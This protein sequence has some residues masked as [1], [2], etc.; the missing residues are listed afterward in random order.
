MS[1][2]GSDKLFGHQLSVS[3]LIEGKVEIV[4]Q[5]FRRQWHKHKPGADTASQG[6]QF[7]GS[8]PFRQSVITTQDGKQQAL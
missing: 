2:Q 7:G 4:L 3:G 8:E 5:L 1:C 6:Q